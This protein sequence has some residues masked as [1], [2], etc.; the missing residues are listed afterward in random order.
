MHI[1]DSPVKKY[2]TDFA[3]FE[4]DASKIELH[5]AH[6]R[7]IRLPYSGPLPDAFREN[8]GAYIFVNLAVGLKVGTCLVI[9]EGKKDRRYPIEATA[10]EINDILFPFFFKDMGRNK[11]HTR[12]G[13]GLN[14]YW[15]GNFQS[16]YIHWR[17]FVYEGYGIDGVFN[18]LSSKALSWVIRYIDEYK[19]IA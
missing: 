16:S 15:L 17:R 2:K 19:R 14:D 6:K 7:E 18:L 4:L 1:K 8:D 11:Y 12:F 3:G 10:Q 9:M 13:N 5:S